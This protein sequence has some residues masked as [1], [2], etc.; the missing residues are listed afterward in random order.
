MT[1]DT[2]TTL[3]GKFNIDLSRNIFTLSHSEMASVIEAA[4]FVK[5]RKPKNANGS[6][7]RY[8]FRAMQRAATNN[9]LTLNP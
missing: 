6:R 2:A 3:A 7:G 5:Y 4:D 9:P 8:F 1:K